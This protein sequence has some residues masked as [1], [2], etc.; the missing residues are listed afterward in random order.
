LPNFLR[1]CLFDLDRAARSFAHDQ[2]C[3]PLD[4]LAIATRHLGSR[5]YLL[6]L[7]AGMWALGRNGDHKALERLGANSFNSVA[8]TA[9]VMEGVKRAIGR[10]RPTEAKWAGDWCGPAVTSPSFPSGHTGNVAAIF[11]AATLSTERPWIAALGV[12]AVAMVAAGR[13]IDERHWASDVIVGSVVGCVVAALV[14]RPASSA[15]RPRIDADQ[16]ARAIMNS[17]RNG[18]SVQPSGRRG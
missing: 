14:S 4:I 3:R 11:T 1:D 16:P 6:P 18:N 9:I 15:A 10:P 8:T 17:R 13:I 2:A 5:F 7:A 12:G